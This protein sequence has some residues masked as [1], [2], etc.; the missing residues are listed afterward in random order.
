MIVRQ[1]LECS[2]APSIFV[3][4]GGYNLEATRQGCI[5]YPLRDAQVSHHWP[6]VGSPAL[7][8]NTDQHIKRPAKIAGARSENTMTINNNSAA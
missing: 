1:I 3:L 5:N 4:E 7:F 6:E 2:S 8:L